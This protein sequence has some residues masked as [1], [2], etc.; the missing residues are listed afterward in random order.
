M[1]ATPTPALPEGR[2]RS[3]YRRRPPGAVRPIRDAVDARTTD[4]PD[5]P[6]IT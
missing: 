6:P 2:R 4:P 3:R 5:G 1:P